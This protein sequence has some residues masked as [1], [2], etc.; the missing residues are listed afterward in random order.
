MSFFDQSQ[1]HSGFNLQYL[2]AGIRRRG[3][4]GGYHLHFCS[5]L[6]SRQPLP[7]IGRITSLCFL[8]KTWC[9]RV[10]SLVFVFGT[11][12]SGSLHRTCTLHVTPCCCTT[13]VEHCINAHTPQ[14]NSVFLVYFCEKATNYVFK[15]V[16]SWRKAQWPLRRRYLTVL[17]KVTWLVFPPH[18]TKYCEEHDFGSTYVLV[19]S[20]AKQP[21]ST[22][23]HWRRVLNL[24]LWCLIWTIKFIQM[25]CGSLKCVY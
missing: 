25:D 24:R 10:K 19:Y 1:K 5:A 13:E 18:A 23:L 14:R 6:R 3:G 22:P 8:K 15:A 7:L 11:Q 20:P 12:K 21:S 16:M 17:C 4:V 9:D 2:E